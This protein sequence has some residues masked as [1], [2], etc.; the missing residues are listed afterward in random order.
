MGE[1]TWRLTNIDR[2]EPDASLFQPPADYK[3][4]DASETITITYTRP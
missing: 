4:E 1:S 3:V 2:T